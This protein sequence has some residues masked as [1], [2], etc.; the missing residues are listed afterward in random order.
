MNIDEAVNQVALDEFCRRFE[1]DSNLHGPRE[2]LTI[3][4]KETYGECGCYSEYTRDDVLTTEFIVHTNAG[5]VSFNF[6]HGYMGLE[7][8]DAIEKYTEVPSIEDYC[9][10]EG[11]GDDYY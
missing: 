8:S 5:D 1:Y 9:R 11:R 10:I 4:I 7:L 6:T 3:S 2:D